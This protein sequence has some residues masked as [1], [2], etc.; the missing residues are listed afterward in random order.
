M[1]RD[2][3][4]VGYNDTAIAALLPVPLT[5]VSLPLGGM[6]K[7]AVDLLIDLI[8]GGT[9]D[10]ILHTPRLIARASSGGEPAQPPSSD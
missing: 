8:E 3:S 6:G 1:P 4:V 2:L 9:P 10:S 7:E 5:S